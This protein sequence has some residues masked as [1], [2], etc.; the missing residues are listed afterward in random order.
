M[1]SLVPIMRAQR[2]NRDINFEVVNFVDHTILLV[3]TSRPCLPID[4]ML[5][6]FHLSSTCSR[7]FLQ[8]NQQAGNLLDSLFVT[9]ALDGG[10]FRLRLFRKIDNVSHRLQSVDHSHNVFLG[11]QSREFRIRAMRLSDIVCHSLHIAAVGKE[12]I[13][14]WTHLVGVGLKG[15]FQKLPCQPVAVSA[16]K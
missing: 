7:M 14:R 13:A 10:K 5:Q 1:I 8:F 3:N 12:W 4:E 11:L 6:M 16:R 2:Y 9:T 15:W